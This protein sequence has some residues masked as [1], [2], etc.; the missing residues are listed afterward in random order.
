LSERDGNVFI[1]RY[2]FADSIRDIARRYMLTES[3]VR[4]ILNRTRNQLRA[5]LVKEGYIL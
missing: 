5:R 4:V 3:N 1:R 2:F